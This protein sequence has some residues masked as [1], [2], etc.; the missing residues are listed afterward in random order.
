MERYIGTKEIKARESA[1]KDDDGKAGMDVQYPDSYQSWSPIEA[2]DNAYKKD[3]EMGYGEALFLLKKGK[4]VCRI[5]WNGKGLFIFLVPE[6]KYHASGNKLKTLIGTYRDD[7]VPYTAYLAIKSV[8]GTITPWAA[9]QTDTLAED[10]M[11]VT[12]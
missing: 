11:E 3:G 12:S 9:S 1:R 4:K 10:W 7:M 8:D 2:F 6:N 5:G